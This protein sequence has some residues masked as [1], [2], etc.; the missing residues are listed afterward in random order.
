MC[1]KFYNF[2]TENILFS[3]EN[4]VYLQME[5]N[6]NNKSIKYGKVYKRVLS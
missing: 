3:A 1:G 5:K 6:S 4:V 2:L